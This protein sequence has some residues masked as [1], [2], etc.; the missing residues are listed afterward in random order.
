[1]E[2]KTLSEILSYTNDILELQTYFY[3]MSSDMKKL[4]QKGIYVT[5]FD[6]SHIHYHD[7]SFSFLAE[8]IDEKKDSIVSNIYDCSMLML[9]TY[10]SKSELGEVGSQLSKENI[11]SYLSMMQY[12]IPDIDASYFQQLFEMNQVS[13]Y[14]DYVNRIRQIT[15]GGRGEQKNLVKATA[16]GSLLTDEEP[17]NKAAFVSVPAVFVMAGILIVVMILVYALFLI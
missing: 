4:H 10:A 16:V 15:E 8:N 13:Y 2:N 17:L 9:K 3:Q 6:P 12:M 1:M 5:N 14:H 7:G 11:L